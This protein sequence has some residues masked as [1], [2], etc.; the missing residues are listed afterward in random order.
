LNGIFR[1]AFLSLGSVVLC[2]L[3]QKTKEERKV[4]MNVSERRLKRRW[5]NTKEEEEEAQ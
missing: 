2:L 4:T 3:V 5:V 1:A